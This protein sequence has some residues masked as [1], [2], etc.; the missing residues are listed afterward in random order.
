MWVVPGVRVRL[1]TDD[2]DPSAVE[3]LFGEVKAFHLLPP[4]EGNDAIFEATLKLTEAGDLFWADTCS[5]RADN[6][7]AWVRARDLWWRDASDWM[8]EKLRYGPPIDWDVDA[9]E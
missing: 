8:G 3:L 1:D 6:S 9:P 7:A 5:A 2:T 4:P